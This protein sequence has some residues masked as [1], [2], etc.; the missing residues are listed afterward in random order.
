M[1]LD[2]LICVVVA[3][4]T[5]NRIPTLSQKARKDGAP[6]GIYGQC[7]LFRVLDDLE[8][9]RMECDSPFRLEFLRYNQRT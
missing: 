4:Q 7:P 6:S 3:E 5:E 2:A 1:S 8:I 9:L